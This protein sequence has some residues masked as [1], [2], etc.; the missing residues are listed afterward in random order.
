MPGVSLFEAGFKHSEE[1]DIADES[2]GCGVYEAWRDLS[3]EAFDVKVGA[4]VLQQVDKEVD[5]PFEWECDELFGSL[6]KLFLHFRPFDY[7]QLMEFDR[8]NREAVYQWSHSQHLFAAF[9]RKSQYEV[10]PLMDSP[11]GGL[12][13]SLLCLSEGVAAV[14]PLEGFVIAGL[15]AVFDDNYVFAGQ[16]R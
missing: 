9:T 6:G 3:H 13:Y 11:L 16:F 5:I 14:Y 10:C 15:Y 2:P 4:E 1:F 12:L 8:V 7:L